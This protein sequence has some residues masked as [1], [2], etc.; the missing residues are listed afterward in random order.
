MHQL[1]SS[2][3]Q[4]MVQNLC[5]VKIVCV[6]FSQT[7]GT[8]FDH[9]PNKCI[10]LSISIGVSDSIDDSL[11]HIH[12]LR[13]NKERGSATERHQTQNQPSG[14]AKLFVFAVLAL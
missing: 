14:A 8:R 13:R 1:L 3:V 7:V 12:H 9:L 5:Y 10:R 6:S 2:S 4:I 11:G